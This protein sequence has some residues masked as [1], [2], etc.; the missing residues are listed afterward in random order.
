MSST[1][2][3]AVADHQESWPA[4]ELE[5]LDRRH[6]IHQMHRGDVPDRTVIVRG[7]GCRAW[8]A[9][10]NERPDASGGGV[11]HSPLGHGRPER[12]AAAAAQMTRIEYFTGQLEFSNDQAILL[13]ARL[14]GLAPEG[15]NKVFF[16]NGG[17]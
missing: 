4:Q 10:G 13:A 9:R 8:D 5:D 12:A 6:L 1:D 11:W 14:A 2:T 16:A 7:E 15:M 3:V 17:S